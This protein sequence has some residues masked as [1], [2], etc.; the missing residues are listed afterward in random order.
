LILLARIPLA[1]T[2]LG[3]R[4]AYFFL[5]LGRDHAVEHYAVLIFEVVGDLF[6]IERDIDKQ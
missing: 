4:G 3:R 2:F 1:T 6:H 5:D